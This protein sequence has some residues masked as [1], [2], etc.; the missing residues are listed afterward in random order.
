[1]KTFENLYYEEGVFMEKLTPEVI[2]ELA[3]AISVAGKA[4]GAGLAMG[5]GAIGPAFGEGYIG[6]HAMDAIARQPE[7]ANVITTRM[8]LADA[9]AETTGIYSLVIAFMILFAL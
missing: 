4:I 8:I 7:L 9:I 1:M 5:I 6:A 3:K 2:S